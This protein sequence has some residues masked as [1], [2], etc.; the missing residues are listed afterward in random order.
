[1]D[2]LNL[3]KDTLENAAKFCRNAEQASLETGDARFPQNG[4][5]VM[6]LLSTGPAGNEGVETVILYCTPYGYLGELLV[7]D[8]NDDFTAS[9]FFVKNIRHFIFKLAKANYSSWVEHNKDV[10][11]AIEDGEIDINEYLSDE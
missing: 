9:Y 8:A 11:K 5:Y 6:F 2:D 3:S 1:M 10:L 4:D 7:E